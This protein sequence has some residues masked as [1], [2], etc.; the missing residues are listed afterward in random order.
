MINPAEIS[1]M[2]HRLGLGDKT[3]EKDY[4]AG[5]AE[6]LNAGNPRSGG[7]DPRN[8]PRH[9]EIFLGSLRAP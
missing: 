8:V 1:K 9:P 3:I 7:S 4:V 5:P 2:A 6:W